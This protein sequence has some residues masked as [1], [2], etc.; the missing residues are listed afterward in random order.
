MIVNVYRPPGRDLNGLPILENWLK[1]I[2]EMVLVVGDFN[3]NTLRN[4]P[5]SREYKNLLK[6]LGLKNMVNES[7]AFRSF[8]KIKY[9]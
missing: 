8:L 5:M 1:T 3:I 6:R 9:F 7:K 2:N 4:T